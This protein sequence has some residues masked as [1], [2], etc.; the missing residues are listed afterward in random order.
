M[1]TAST[2]DIAIIGAGPYGLSLAAHLRRRRQSVRIFGSPMH[3]WSNHMPQGMH[4]KSEGFASN[5]YDPE[6][7]FTLEAYCA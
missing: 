6:G 5:L 2:V 3:A 7:K 4:L 1:L